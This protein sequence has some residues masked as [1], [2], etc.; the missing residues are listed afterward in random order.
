MDMNK[1][2]LDKLSSGFNTLL[3]RKTKIFKICEIEITDDDKEIIL[4]S[5]ELRNLIND[6]VRQLHLAD[7]FK[8]VDSYNGENKEAQI[9]MKAMIGEYMFSKFLLGVYK[10]NM[11]LGYSITC[12]AVAEMILNKKKQDIVIEKND[13]SNYFNIDLKSQFKNNTFNY[14]TVNIESF[15]RMKQ[16]A[17]FF[18]GAVIDGNQNSID[19]NHK[20]AFYFINNEYFEKNAVQVLTSDFKNFTPYF[21]LSLNLLK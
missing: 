5:I 18:V 1:I 14:L 7:K 19:T 12:P 11:K 4:K 8:R 2:D 17:D 16:K 9:S 6:N 13:G 20:V 15:K 21:K 10:N 3:N